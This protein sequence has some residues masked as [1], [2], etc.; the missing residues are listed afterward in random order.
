MS[1]PKKPTRP[2]APSLLIEFAQW[3]E[4]QDDDAVG[5]FELTED[6]PG[7]GHFQT[8]AESKRFSACAV[9]FA[10]T[11]DGSEIVLVDR[12][13]K[14]PMAVVFLNSEGGEI[15]LGASPEEFLL[16]LAKADTG[17]SDL[18]DE[19]ATGRKKLAAWLKKKQVRAP[20]APP[21]DLGAFLDPEG[22][23]T[24]EAAPPPRD[25]GG[26]D[27]LPPMARRLAMFVGRRVD[28][29][30]FV[31]F[32]TQEMKKKVPASLS[33]IEDSDWIEG[34][35]KMGFDVLLESK[36]LHDAFPEIPK[37]KT[38]YIPYVAGIYY[39]EKSVEL[40][41]GVTI[42]MDA[43]G[44]EKRLGPPAGHRP[45]SKKPYWEVPIDP[46][47]ALIFAASEGGDF[48]LRIDAALELAS[49]DIPSRPVVGLFVAWA[50]ER[51]LFNTARLA[52]HADL[53]S[54]VKARKA[55]GS[56]LVAAAL[57]RGL[58]D[59]HLVDK[60]GLRLFAY[61]WFNH[62][63][64]GYIRDDLVAVFGSREN[65]YG[66]DEPVLDDDTW[67]AVDRASPRLDRVFA[68][69]L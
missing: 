5:Y 14:L 18:D 36:L 16:A 19:D 23:P 34:G 29:P 3:L 13:A 54:K 44:L 37:S 32:V 47:I 15:T 26:Y 11:G 22:S 8:K 39:R 48:S 69:W 17:I 63:D 59:D 64:E 6:P 61:S 55:R 30:E 66:H 10:R 45:T 60:P 51:G 50:I 46:K 65:E 12:G 67:E 21:F 28:D 40:P 27:R 38:S 53:I 52:A 57:P 2:A 68:E 24:I 9:P 58:W 43:A 7:E 4:S 42:D 41:F 31:T 33:W 1:K 49:R 62:L 56:G 25:L 20:K 35:K